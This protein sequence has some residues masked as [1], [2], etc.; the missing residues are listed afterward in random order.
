[1]INFFRQQRT[2]SN[3]VGVDGFGYW[4]GLD[5]RV[6]FHP[7][8]PNQGITFVRSDLVPP[9]V[10]PALV[11][12]RYEIPRRSSLAAGLAKVEMVEHVMAALTGLKIDN[13]EVWVSGTE[14]PGCDGSSLPF[15]EALESAGAVEQDALRAQLVVDEPARVGD[16]ESWL[17]A[18]PSD[19]HR[20]TI[21]C[22]IDYGPEGPIG[23]QAMR[24]DITP[25][26]L[27]NELAA[28]R[29][30][31]LEP[32]AVWLRSK[33]LG[34]RVTCR[35]LLVFGPDGPID[36]PLRFENECVRH[37]V[38]DLVGD[39]GLAGCDIVGHISVHC[40]GHRLNAELVQTLLA[41]EGRAQRLRK[42]A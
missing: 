22:E 31:L 30:F 41:R 34:C 32:E 17:E 9:R 15:V 2:I 20:L 24:I 40:G 14:L 25:D 33:G 35:D 29:T 6:E 23:R 27:R 26:T 42:S 13:C 16:S 7:A 39:L 11:H 12:H 3:I 28:A 21:Q 19:A 38:L 1:M 18:R 5:V 37:K 8:P 4:S 36:N 10:I